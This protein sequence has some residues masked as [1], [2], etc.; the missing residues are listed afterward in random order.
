MEKTTN[1]KTEFHYLT[2]ESILQYFESV[3]QALKSYETMKEGLICDEMRAKTA[4]NTNNVFSLDFLRNSVNNENLRCL[5]SKFKEDY[6]NI[7][8]EQIEKRQRQINHIKTL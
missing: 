4:I 8:R 2:K 6:L 1:T 5:I 7:L 3:E